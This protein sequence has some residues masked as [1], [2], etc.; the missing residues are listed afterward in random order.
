MKKLSILILSLVCISLLSCR[1]FGH[2][3]NI[4][5]AETGH[6]YSMNAW[7]NKNKARAVDEF[8]NDRIGDRSNMS[9]V[10][11]SIDGQITLAD[12]TR[13][14]IKKYPGH[15][16]IKLDKQDNSSEAYHRIRSMCEGIKEVIAK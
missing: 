8:M 6:Y 9:F 12:R 1:R 3:T 11:T 15:I 13:F 16:E 10:N 4:A 2:N 5:Y 7:F 14:Y